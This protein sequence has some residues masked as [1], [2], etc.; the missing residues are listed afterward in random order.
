MT[1]KNKENIYVGER[2]SFLKKIAINKSILN[3]GACDSPFHNEKLKSDLLLHK[4]LNEVASN[5]I[6]ID[7]D[8]DA[9]KFLKTKKI[10]NIHN[11]NFNSCFKKFNTKSYKLDY[12]F[13]GET[14][15]H[16]M[17]F[18]DF[19]LNIKKIMNYHD[20]KLVITTPNVFFIKSMI[21]YT[22]GKIKYHPDHTVL[23]SDEILSSLLLKYNLDVEFSGSCF[24]E[25][26][27]FSITDKIV[28]KISSFF[29]H[30]AETLVIICKQKK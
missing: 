17:N 6:G 7:I 29:P 11:F 19:F 20:A 25:R 16:L 22:R 12:I 8:Q 5:C 1:G 2:L 14:I 15:E 21:N 4:H 9:I 30:I 26:P 13:F 23:F 27:Y 18:D 3:I 10:S 24:M 28:R